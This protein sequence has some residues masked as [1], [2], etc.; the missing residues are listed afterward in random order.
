MNSIIS[1]WASMPGDLLANPP[2]MPTNQTTTLLTNLRNFIAPIV[3]IVIAGV[4]ISFLIRRQVSQFV[5][6]IAIAIGVMV[7]FYS[8]E[9]IGAAAKL[10]SG[11]LGGTPGGTTPGP[12]PGP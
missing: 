12:A 8:P 10:F 6:F 9:I 3:F 1:I 2:A 5:Q 7:L 4:A 11:W